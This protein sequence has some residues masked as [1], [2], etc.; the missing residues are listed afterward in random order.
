MTAQKL[1]DKRKS[2][3]A[4][5]AFNQ[6]T[7]CKIKHKIFNP[8]TSTAVRRAETRPCARGWNKRPGATLHQG[9]FG[10][11]WPR[12]DRGSTGTD[13]GNEMIQLLAL[14]SS[15]P[16]A[17]SNRS[18]HP[19]SNAA[20]GLN[21]EERGTDESCRTPAASPAAHEHVP[22]H[23]STSLGQA[24]GSDSS[25]RQ[26]DCGVAGTEENSSVISTVRLV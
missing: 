5:Q 15:D 8:L 3:D 24:W 4:N 6:R 23:P 19:F 16:P 21:A 12:E 26:R 14:G 10:D 13:Q 17:A 18:L 11:T 9:L 25:S 22:P 20:K 2:K 1:T 7:C